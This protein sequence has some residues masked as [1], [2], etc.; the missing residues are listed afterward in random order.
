MGVTPRSLVAVLTAAALLAVATP[1]AADDPPL[2]NWAS[3]L[4]GLPSAYDPSSADDCKSGRLKCVDAMLRA[5]ERRLDAVENACDHDAVF[6]L[7]YYLTTQE[8]KRAVTEPG[9]FGDPN[10]ITHEGAVFT[11]FYFDAYD[12][13]HSGNKA[14]TPPAWAIAFQAAARREVSG[15][16]NLLLGINAHISQDRPYVLEKIGLRRPDGSSR[17]D[18]HDKVNAF[19][20]RVS[21]TL[22]EQ[23]AK[24]LDPSVDD[25]DVP[26]TLDDLLKF[27][28]IPTWRETAW[29]HAELLISARTREERDRIAEEID[30][31]AA[32]QALMI[33]R[34]TAYLPGLQN[35]AQRDAYCALNHG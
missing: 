13:W 14:A 20:N 4:P 23:V 6:A 31:Y 2:V 26:G 27:Q 3:L 28:L 15:A 24:R 9:F 21:D 35:S 8:L 16:G 32:G 25:A 12:S 1:A 5:M 22:I 17:K 34:L 18:D 7:A 33:R 10:F 11:A 30:A 29:R 19:L